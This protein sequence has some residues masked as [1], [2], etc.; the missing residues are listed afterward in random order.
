MEQMIQQ[1]L[2]GLKPQPT[3]QTPIPATPADSSPL[4]ALLQ[5]L[6]AAG[7]T[8]VPVP[9][10]APTPDLTT[11][12]SILALLQNQ[13]TAPVPPSPVLTPDST[14]I[15]QMQAQIDRLQAQKNPPVQ[16][17]PAPV[18]TTAP[19]PVTTPAPEGRP[20][21][22]TETKDERNTVF[23]PYCL[24]TDASRN[25]FDRTFTTNNDSF[26]N[27]LSLTTAHRIPSRVD[28]YQNAKGKTVTNQSPAH[29]KPST[30]KVYTMLC[31]ASQLLKHGHTYA[32]YPNTCICSDDVIRAHRDLTAA[33]NEVVA[34]KLAYTNWLNEFNLLSQECQRHHLIITKSELF[35]RRRLTEPHGDSTLRTLTNPK[36]SSSTYKKL[37]DEGL[38]Q[39]NDHYQ[40]PMIKATRTRMQLQ[41]AAARIQ[42]NLHKHFDASSSS[43]DDERSSDAEDTEEELSPPPLPK[44]SKPNP[45]TQTTPKKPKKHVPSTAKSPKMSSK[46]SADK[47]KPADKK[48]PTKSPAKKNVSRFKPLPLTDDEDESM[49]T[50]SGGP[51]K[52]RRSTSALPSGKSGK[53]ASSRT[54]SASKAKA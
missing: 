32:T 42:P 9:A 22:M 12:N 47:K 33:A 41:K 7:T 23:S 25:P 3:A 15:A 4:A 18:T 10:P 17:D 45:K 49:S 34:H 35:D 14:I 31:D 21:I 50:P 43:S 46:K 28:S 38:T 16:T 20:A 51:K 8:A 30:F 37:Q 29:V 39:L 53:G 54:R 40:N 52:R 44:K 13:Q 11:I 1:L 26:A 6:A 36:V 24:P 19:E 48:T 27:S 5:Q 2:S